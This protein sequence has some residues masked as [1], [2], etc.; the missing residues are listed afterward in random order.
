[1]RL[2][3]LRRRRDHRTIEDLG[4][5]DVLAHSP[6]R[7][8]RRVEVKE[9]GDLGHHGR[10]PAGVVEVL[11]QALARGFEIDEPRSRCRQLVEA[12]ER[13]IDADA[14]RV[15]DQVD[16][17]IRRAGDGVQSPN[18]VLERIGCEEVARLDVVC[19]SCRHRSH[20]ALLTPHKL[21]GQPKLGA[22]S[23]R[24]SCGPHAATAP[25]VRCGV[26]R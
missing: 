8:G 11:H 25:S 13:Q 15:G 26:D 9:V 7:D 3:R 19:G 21:R 16:D 1:M 24:P 4:A 14:A 5:R 6:A 17:C 20:L 22:R 12:S 10:Q 23:S 18:G 2:E